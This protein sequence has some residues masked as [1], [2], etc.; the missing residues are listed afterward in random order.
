MAR[1]VV[2]PRAGAL[3]LFC[4]LLL[5]F[6][7]PTAARS[8]ETDEEYADSVDTDGDGLTDG[9]ERRLGTDP[10]RADTDGDGLED[11][12]EKLRGTDPVDAESY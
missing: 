1:S 3:A 12:D 8:A 5:L 11:G 9:A 7:V 10:A 2:K 4:A 6:G